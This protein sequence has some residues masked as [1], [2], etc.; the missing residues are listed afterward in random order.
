MLEAARELHKYFH[1]CK[2]VL[3]MIYEKQNLLTDDLGR[4]RASVRHL[5]RNLQSF[6]ADL[7]PLGNEVGIVWIRLSILLIS[8]TCYTLPKVSAVQE[9]ASRLLGSYAGD[10]AKDIQAKEN[11][12]IEAW[13]NLHLRVRRRMEKLHDADDLYRFLMAV[14]DQMLWMNDML[15]HIL[16]YEKAK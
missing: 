7:A 8:L 2:E 5:K 12:V 16:T 4:D 3:A 10:K 1:D 9:E 6:E 14:Q 11:E 15:K 13:K